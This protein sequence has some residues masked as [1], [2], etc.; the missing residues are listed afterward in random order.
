MTGAWDTAYTPADNCIMCHSNGADGVADGAGADSMDDEWTTDGHGAAAG[1]DLD[2]SASTDA[3]GC[4]FCH[5][6]NVWTDH[7]PTKNAQELRLRAELQKKANNATPL[8][9]L[10]K[11][12]DRFC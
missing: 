7:V 4:D 5:L 1:G 8:D 2:A 3:G 9:L 6:D 11:T 12:F 10:E